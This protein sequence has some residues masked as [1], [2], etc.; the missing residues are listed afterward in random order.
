MAHPA[1]EGKTKQEKFLK[2]VVIL[3]PKEQIARLGA[4][5]G[6]PEYAKAYAAVLKV[7]GTIPL[8]R[9]KC[10]A[11][12]NKMVRP[13]EGDYASCP[14]YI[15]TQTPRADQ[16]SSPDTSTVPLHSVFTSRRKGA[17]PTPS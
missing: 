8:V 17:T 10:K 12:G 4:C 6:C 11:A 3:T 2:N 9:A 5:L 14:M 15:R 7:G 13:S 1:S 16:S